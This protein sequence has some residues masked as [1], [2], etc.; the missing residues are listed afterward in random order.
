MKDAKSWLAPTLGM[1]HSYKQANIE[2]LRLYMNEFFAGL[3]FKMTPG[4]PLYLTSKKLSP[5]LMQFSWVRLAY[6]AFRDQLKAALLHMETV[7]S[8]SKAGYRHLKN[9]EFLCDWFIPV[10]SICVVPR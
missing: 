8:T 3:H 6:P 9:L 1:W 10:V 5:I 4:Q 7:N 2:V